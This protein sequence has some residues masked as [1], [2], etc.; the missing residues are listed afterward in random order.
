MI[1]IE[2]MTEI[3][4]TTEDMIETEEMTGA[5]IGEMIEDMIGKEEMTE[6]IMEEMSETEEMIE[7]MIGIGEMT[8]AMTETEDMIVEI[9]EMTAEPNLLQ[10]R[11]HQ[12][13][14]R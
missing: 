14:H 6:D 13:L 3:G 11:K 7:A 10:A 12:S 8:G 5:M 4:E 2:D 1:E 9:K